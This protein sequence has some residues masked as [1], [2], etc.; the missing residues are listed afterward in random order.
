MR[1]VPSRLGLYDSTYSAALIFDKGIDTATVPLN[2]IQI[3]E[4]LGFVF[5]IIENSE[6]KDIKYIFSV[7]RLTNVMCSGS[8]NK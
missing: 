6:H 5:D 1:K 8:K 2:L 3:L 4:K 7:K